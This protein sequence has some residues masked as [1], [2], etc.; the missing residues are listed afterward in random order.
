MAL[1]DFRFFVYVCSLRTPS[2][3][4]MEI[5]MALAYGAVKTKHLRLLN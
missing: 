3:S 2:V 4:Q 5:W 1:T